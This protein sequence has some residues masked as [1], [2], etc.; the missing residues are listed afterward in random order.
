M[1]VQYYTVWFILPGLPVA[2]LF[3]IILLTEVKKIPFDVTESEAELGSGYLI[4][5]SGIGFALFIISEY[6]YIL[7]FIVLFNCCF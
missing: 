2:L 7:L 6:S 5:Y 4:E 3:W 1:V